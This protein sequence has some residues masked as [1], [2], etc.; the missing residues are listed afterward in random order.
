MTLGF[1]I[2]IFAVVAGF[3]GVVAIKDVMADNK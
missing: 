2:V 3:I 1:G